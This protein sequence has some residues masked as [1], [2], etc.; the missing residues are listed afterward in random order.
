MQLLSNYYKV[1]F[2]FCFVFYWKAF[3]LNPRNILFIIS[4]KKCLVNDAVDMTPNQFQLN[5]S[6]KLSDGYLSTLLTGNV[7]IF[8]VDLAKKKKN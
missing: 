1:H 8:P 2:V 6:I 7:M 4:V 3:L 5:I